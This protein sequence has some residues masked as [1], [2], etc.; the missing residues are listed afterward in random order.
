V[1]SAARTSL[2]CA[3]APRSNARAVVDA[4]GDGD[5]VDPDRMDA[6]IDRLTRL[7]AADG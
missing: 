1:T 3:T 2:D 5:D 6:A 7:L 4:W